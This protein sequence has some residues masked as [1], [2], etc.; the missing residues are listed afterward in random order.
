[1]PKL[2]IIS[3]TSWNLF[4]F[5]LPLM[6]MLREEGYE[7]VAVAP[8]DE[9]S[10]RLLE[11]GFRFIDLPMNNKGTNPVEDIALA[12]RLYK[13]FKCEQPDV[14][15]T[16]TPK[17]NI[18]ASI[19]GGLS[20]TPV[21]PNISGLG[22]VFI[23][24]S[25]VTRIVKFLYRLALRFPPKVFFQNHDDLNLFVEFGLVSESKAQRIPGSGINAIFYT[26]EKIEKPE[27]QGFIFLLV[28]ACCGTKG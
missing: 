6:T 5:R 14:V 22:N 19:A 27:G 15:L 26:P 2:L 18:Y 23:R 11:A 12:M 17:P 10:S 4:N 21:I 24:Q 16:Y 25:M 7:V 8:Y 28:A 20:R 3:N 13:L 1:M 9:Y